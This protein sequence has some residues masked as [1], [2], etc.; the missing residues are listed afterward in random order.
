MLLLLLLL[1]AL[2]VLLHYAG[3]WLNLRKNCNHHISGHEPVWPAVMQIIPA[4]NGRAG[5]QL[6][7]QCRPRGGREGC[8]QVQQPADTRRV[9]LECSAMGGAHLLC[10]LLCLLRCELLCL[11]LAGGLLGQHCRELRVV[12]LIDLA[13]QGEALGYLQSARGCHCSTIASLVYLTVHIFPQ[14]GWRGRT[15]PC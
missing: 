5:S 15:H 9:M 3:L 1:E 11:T 6:N 2:E 10:A 8:N 12:G 13:R 4:L 7:A 14:P